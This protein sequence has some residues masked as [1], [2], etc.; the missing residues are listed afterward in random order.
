[1]RDGN[2]STYWSPSGTTGHISVKWG[3]ATTVSTINIREAAGSE[4]TIGS[5]QVVNDATGA[6]LASGSGA[7]AIT[8]A[9][10]STDE[11]H[12]RDHQRERHPEGRRVRDLRLSD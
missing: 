3:T 11:D 6:V 5:W 4:G 12:L 9:A 10:T 7:G 8:F 2:L 1:M